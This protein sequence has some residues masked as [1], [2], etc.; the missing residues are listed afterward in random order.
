MAWHICGAEKYWLR[1]VRIEPEF[2]YPQQGQWTRAAFETALDGIERQY[3][4]VFSERPDS[5]NIF[6][7]LGRVCQHNLSHWKSMEHLRMLQD[8][9][10]RQPDDTSWGLAVDYMTE[11]LILGGK[12]PLQVPR[13]ADA[14]CAAGGGIL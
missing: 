12:A 11:L 10:W 3:E 5:R 14:C 1:E 2:E 13:R 6:F 7:G 4:K 8:A 9:D